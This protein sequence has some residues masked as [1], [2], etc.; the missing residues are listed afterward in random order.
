MTVNEIGISSSKDLKRREK[1]RVEVFHSSG[2]ETTNYLFRSDH[3][4]NRMTI[5]HG[6][7]CNINHLN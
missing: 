6:L 1:Y 7:S 3:C 4:Y 2:T 5:A